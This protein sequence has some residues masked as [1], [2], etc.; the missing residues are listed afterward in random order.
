MRGMAG[1]ANSMAPGAESI[2]ESTLND[3]RFWRFL[4]QKKARNTEAVLRANSLMFR[5]R[6][7]GQG[8]CSHAR[9]GRAQIKIDKLGGNANFYRK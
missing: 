2:L 7:I 3:S 5:G 8:T 4:Q 6:N 9:G 1:R